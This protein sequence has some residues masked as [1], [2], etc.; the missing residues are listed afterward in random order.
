MDISSYTTRESGSYTPVAAEIRLT[1]EPR[2]K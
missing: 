1:A 2:R